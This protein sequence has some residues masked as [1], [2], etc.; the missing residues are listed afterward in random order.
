M[1]I[2]EEDAPKAG[3]TQAVEDVGE[4]AQIG[5]GLE[6]HGAG[7]GHEGRRDAVGHDRKDR[8]AEGSAASTA[9]RSARM[10]STDR[11]R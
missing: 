1:A 4:N 7:I 5:L 2:D 3:P 6:R 11:L 8:N 9:T 10:L